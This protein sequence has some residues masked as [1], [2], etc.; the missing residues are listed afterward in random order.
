MN[1][2]TLQR[3]LEALAGNDASALADCDVE[4]AFAAVQLS[5]LSSSSLGDV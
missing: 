4:E 1:I 5:A 3:L 2:S